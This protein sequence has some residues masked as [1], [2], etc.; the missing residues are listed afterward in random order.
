MANLNRPPADI[1]PKDFFETWLPREYDR[2]AA[3]GAPRPPDLVACVRLSGDGGGV[4][5]ITLAGGQLSVAEKDVA[6]EGRTPDVA[7]EQSVADWRAITAGTPGDGPDLS[8]P[9]GASLDSWLVNPALHQVLQTV[10]GTLRFEIPGFQGRTFAVSIT[11][12]GAAEPQATISIDMDTITAMRDGT[13]P[14]VQAFFGGKILMTGDSAFAMQIGM[15][16][17]PQQGG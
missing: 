8:V 16:L 12:R 1:T 5:T 13:L 17:M 14:P 9:D 11:F 2:L 4:W 7:I 6:Q 10:K 15:A 3:E